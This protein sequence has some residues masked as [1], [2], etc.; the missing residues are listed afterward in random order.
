MKTLL[1]QWYRTKP[2]HSDIAPVYALPFKRFKD[3]HMCFRF[4]TKLTGIEYAEITDVQ[5]DAMY[6]PVEWT[7]VDPDR[8]KNIIREL[9]RPKLRTDMEMLMIRWEKVHK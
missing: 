1:G 4:A 5:M 3:A 7:E 8:I 9:L 6:E 2:E